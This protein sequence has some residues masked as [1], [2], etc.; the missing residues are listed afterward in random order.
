M[1]EFFAGGRDGCRA[2]RVLVTVEPGE[3]N[4]YGVSFGSMSL[5]DPHTKAM[6][7]DL[8]DM[9]TRMGLR[10]EGE[11]VSVDCVETGQ[12]GCAL[13]ISCGE[14]R[15]YIFGCTDDVIGAFLAG[16]LPAGELRQDGERWILVPD[17]P[18]E[19]R[20]QAVLSQFC[21]ENG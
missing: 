3:L 12:G 4:D 11:R 5:Y 8:I 15:E 17:A 16:G 10:H 20:E 21:A 2:D 13:L 19:E 1:I 6:L 9:V 18:P 14:R 7:R